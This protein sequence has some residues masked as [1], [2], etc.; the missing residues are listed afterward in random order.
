LK[1]SPQSTVGELRPDIPFHIT[2]PSKAVDDG[3]R[4]KETQAAPQLKA[5]EGGDGNV[6]R[7]SF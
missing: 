5:G 6:E 3:H 7:K 1:T 2:E 4:G